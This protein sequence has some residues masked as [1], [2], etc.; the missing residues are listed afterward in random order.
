MELT[1]EFFTAALNGLATKADL[2]HLATREDL[3]T[4]SQSMAEIRHTLDS[5]TAVLDGIA[6]DVKDW[7][8]EIMAVRARLDRHDQWFKQ[9][10]D[11]LNLKLHS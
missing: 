8:T 4:I 2:A 5:H 6:R 9:V 1:Q 7:N 3:D 10:A 11:H